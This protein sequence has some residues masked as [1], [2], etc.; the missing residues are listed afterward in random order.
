V[1]INAV[2]A[3]LAQ[4]SHC[5]NRSQCWTHGVAKRIAP[6]IS[7]RPESEREFMFGP[8]RVIYLVS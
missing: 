5:F 3:D 1:K 6:A 8:W 2:G 4:H 7:H